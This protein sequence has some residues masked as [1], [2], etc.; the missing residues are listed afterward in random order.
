M[1]T[2]K[3]KRE[4]GI[5]RHNRRLEESRQSGLKALREWHENQEN[6][7]RN[8]HRAKHDKKHNRNKLDHDCILCQDILKEERRQQTEKEGSIR[9]R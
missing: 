1:A 2:K 6:M 9:A 4:R 5:E 3:Q 8:S 7:L